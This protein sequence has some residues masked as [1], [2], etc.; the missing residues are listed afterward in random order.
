MSPIK[1]KKL[2][3]PGPPTPKSKGCKSKQIEKN[4]ANASKTIPV[5]ILDLFDVFILLLS[6]IKKKYL[7]LVVRYIKKRL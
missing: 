4:A 6:E 3:C 2:L 1:K 7:E 5:T